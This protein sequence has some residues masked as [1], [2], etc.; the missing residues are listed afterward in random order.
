MNIEILLIP[1]EQGRIRISIYDFVTDYEVYAD[2]GELTV[3][4]SSVSKE[5]AINMAMENLLKSSKG[6]QSF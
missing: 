3:H 2:L 1:T 6:G 4:E 5:E